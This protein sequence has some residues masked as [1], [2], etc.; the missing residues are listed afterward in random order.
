MSRPDLSAMSAANWT[1]G[2][3][4]AIKN[5]DVE[6]AHSLLMGMAVYHPN[7]AEELRQT[8]LLG[9]TMAKGVTA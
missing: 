5:Q 3:T 8:I 1:S 4:A 9:L 7:E 6:A 2:I